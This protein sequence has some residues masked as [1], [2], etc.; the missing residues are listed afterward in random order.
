MTIST[1]QLEYWL[2]EKHQVDPR[3]R[4][5]AKEIERLRAVIDATVDTGGDVLDA[6]AL[7]VQDVYILVD[8]INHVAHRK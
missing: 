1:R 5:A 3:L 2:N 7:A 6:L 8:S 4:E